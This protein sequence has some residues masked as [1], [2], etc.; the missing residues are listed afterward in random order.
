MIEIRK[1]PISNNTV[2]INEERQFYK[3]KKKKD[4]FKEDN[5]IFCKGKENETTETLF[6]LKEKHG[7][8]IRVFQNK[9]PVL[10][11]QKFK[12][13]TSD[14]YESWK[15]HGN[16]EVIVLTEKH[17]ECPYDFSIS[18]WFDILKVFK[19]RLEFNENF[20]E[21]KYCLLFINFGKNSGASIPHAHA[22]LISF[23]IIPD[24]ILTECNSFSENKCCEL[25]KKELK[26]NRLVFKNKDFIIFTN[27]ASRFPFETHIYSRKH[28]G[29]IK[30]LSSETLYSLS[31]SIN[32]LMTAY[33]KT[34]NQIDFNM[35]FHNA[36]IGKNYHFHI[37]IYP[38]LN[39]FA[40]VEYGTGIIVNTYKPESCAR[41][42]RGN[43]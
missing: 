24:N 28:I 11:L 10:K 43:I 31:E 40:S 16:S 20:E 4:S 34:F 7:W 37:E 2:I 15:G 3:V 1:D 38:Q 14:F 32:Q 30:E 26:S 17:N 8:T 12:G 22:Q 42:L 27:Y 39:K 6:E 41:I 29:S 18:K 35:V 36:P 23:P 33:K 21:I 13:I 19:S 9:F 5:C 25:I